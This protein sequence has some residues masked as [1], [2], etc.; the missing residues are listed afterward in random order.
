MVLFFADEN[1]DLLGVEETFFNQEIHEVQCGLCQKNLIWR[2][3]S[4]GLSGFHDKSRVDIEILQG[5]TVNEDNA[6][7][8]VTE[9]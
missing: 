4:R 8:L 9:S 6:Q 7:M 5:F 3:G 2:T 1:L